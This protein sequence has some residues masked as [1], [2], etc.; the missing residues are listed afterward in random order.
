MPKIKHLHDTK[1]NHAIPIVAF[2]RPGEDWGLLS[3]FADTPIEMKTQHGTRVFPT[4][5]HYFQYMKDP[6]N[7]KYLDAILKG[8]AQHARDFG[9]KHFAEL[10]KKRDTEKEL[11][12]HS[13][14]ADKA[15][16][17]ALKAKLKQHPMVAYLL[18]ATGKACIVEDTGTRSPKN[19][20][21]VWGWK[22][23]GAIVHSV[24]K[25]QTAPG[26]KLGRLWM[27]LRGEMNKEKNP[28]LAA[29]ALSDAAQ[30][31]MARQHPDKNLTELEAPKGKEDVETS[32]KQQLLSALQKS[33]L[34][35]SLTDIQLVPGTLEDNKFKIK[36][37]FNKKGDAP[38]FYR[39]IGFIDA[40][41]E[42][43]SLTITQDLFVSAIT[44]KMPTFNIEKL[45]AEHEAKLR[46]EIATVIIKLNKEI[47]SRKKSAFK[48]LFKDQTDVKKAKRQALQDIANTKGL[49][50]LMSKAESVLADKTKRDAILK[51][52]HSHRTKDI[53]SQLID[54]DELKKSDKKPKV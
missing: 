1:E 46:Q 43:T 37:I 33:E 28:E 34:S 30:K 7:K 8:D 51:H 41:M 2:D 5:E 50:K 13:G 6:E 44:R 20:D 15:M 36:L 54:L 24:V 17:D 4:V 45:K 16:E 32:P 25:D 12:W 29:Y 27:K 22:T 42:A 35:Y 14:G 49:D 31:V 9:R 52:K 21:P 53:F 39:S 26:N 38:L 10:R 47:D 23:G 11:A 40:R 3:N 48:F 18:Q 19:Q